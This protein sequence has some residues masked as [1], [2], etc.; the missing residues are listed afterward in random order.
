MTPPASG[1]PVGRGGA[2]ARPVRSGSSA[3]GGPPGR[4]GLRRGGGLR[5]CAPDRPGRGGAGVQPI[6][7]GS[8]SAL[9]TSTGRRGG[10]R[11]CAPGRETDPL[12]GRACGNAAKR[13]AA[14]PPGRGAEGPAFNPSAVVLLRRCAPRPGGGEGPGAARPAGKP[15]RCAAGPAATQRSDSLRS[16]PAGARRGRRSTHPQCFFFGAAHLD[17]AEGRAQALRARQGNRSA[18]RPGLRQRSEA[19]RCAPARPGRAGVRASGTGV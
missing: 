19:I 14:L 15:I 6:R 7:S 10:P 17:R 13:F 12:R 5:R 3:G 9:R 4:G 8:S 16:R 2:G 1:A 18:A 11:R